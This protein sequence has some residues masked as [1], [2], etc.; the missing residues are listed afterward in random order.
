MIRAV[1]TSLILIFAFDYDPGTGFLNPCKFLSYKSSSSIFC[2][3][4]A[5]LGGV[6]GGA[7]HQKNRAIIRSLE[8]PLFQPFSTLKRREGLETEL[9]IDLYFVRKPPYCYS[10]RVNHYVYNVMRTVFLIYF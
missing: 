2:S 9:L 6:L 7:D 5:T 1:E 10:Y 8:F 3:N 4:E